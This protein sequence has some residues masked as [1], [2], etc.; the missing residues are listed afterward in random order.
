MRQVINIFLTSTL[1][2]YSDFLRPAV[3]LLA[4]LRLSLVQSYPLKTLLL[5]FLGFPG[6]LS[7]NESFGQRSIIKS[8]TF[9]IVVIVVVEFRQRI[10]LRIWQRIW[11]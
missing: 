6:S 3:S 7:S 2:Y 4:S 1:T 8:L 11:L 9:V 10:W 5:S